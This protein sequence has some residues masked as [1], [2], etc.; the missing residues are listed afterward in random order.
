MK[1][2]KSEIEGELSKANDKLKLLAS[3]RQIYQEVELKDAALSTARKELDE[4]KE[5]NH[6]LKLNIESLR[7]SFP[8][9]LTKVTKVSHPVPTLE[10]VSFIIINISA[11][12]I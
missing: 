11:F 1:A 2:K 10:Q 7:R 4:C 12:F 6:R 5:K 8:R 3:N 9:F